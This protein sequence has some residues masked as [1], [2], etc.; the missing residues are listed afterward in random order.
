M[1]R[2]RAMIDYDELVMTGLK[3]AVLGVVVTSGMAAMMAIG[4]I[5]WWMR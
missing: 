1:S 3:C 5:W 4:G 2:G